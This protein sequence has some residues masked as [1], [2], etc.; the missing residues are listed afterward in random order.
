LSVSNIWASGGVRTGHQAAQLLA[1]GASAI[2]IAKP[3]LTAAL[4]SSEALQRALDQYEYELKVAMFCTGSQNL[5]Q[6]KGKGI[7]K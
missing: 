4:Q 7:W 6:L 1:M 3:F 2:G 5:E